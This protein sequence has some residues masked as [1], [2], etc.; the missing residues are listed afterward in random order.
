M[1]SGDPAFE[2]ERRC[3]VGS[4]NDRELAPRRSVS[5]IVIY[6]IILISD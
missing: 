5:L 1:C 6:H 4:S 3:S 2:V